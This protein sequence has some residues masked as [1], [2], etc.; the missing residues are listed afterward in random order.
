MANRSQAASESAKSLLKASWMRSSIMLA[1]IAVI[2][3]LILIWLLKAFNVVGMPLFSDMEFFFLNYG[4]AGIFLGTI[5]AGTI[6]PLGSPALVVAAALF[7]VNPVLLIFVASIGFTIGMTVNY[8]L[9][10]R[11][12]RPYVKK[13][14]STKHLKEMTYAWNRWGW[15]IYVIFGLI[16]VLPVEFLS[17]I[18]GFLKTRV[19]T[20]LALSFIP[21][22]IIFAIL[23]YFGQ[24]VGAWLGVI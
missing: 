17:F 21:R 1:F 14:I 7:G 5:A 16:P 3:A 4:L 23:V 24:S 13:R 19:S 8:A 15:I 18:C 22:L 2:A 10:Y 6:V 11:L 20:F 9:A 12:G